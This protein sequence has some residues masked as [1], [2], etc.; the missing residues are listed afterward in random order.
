MM[1]AEDGG[2][3]RYI[4]VHPVFITGLEDRAADETITIQ[5]CRMLLHILRS[6]I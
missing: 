6:I 5:V 1:G 4:I 2:A 3:L